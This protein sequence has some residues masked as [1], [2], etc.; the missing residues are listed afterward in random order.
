MSGNI[1]NLGSI[2]PSIVNKLEDMATQNPDARIIGD[3]GD[4]VLTEFMLTNGEPTGR[5][6]PDARGVKEGTI[7][8]VAHQLMGDFLPAR[9]A[10]RVDGVF[11]DLDGVETALRTRV[12]RC[13]CKRHWNERMRPRRARAVRHQWSD[14]KRARRRSCRGSVRSRLNGRI[15]SV[16]LAGTAFLRWVAP[17]VERARQWRPVRPRWSRTRSRLESSRT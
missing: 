17:W 1:D 7:E 6:I 13:D 2:D 16:A 8:T 11:A 9:E 14:T 10:E 5:V 3:D 15:V 12:E 4:G